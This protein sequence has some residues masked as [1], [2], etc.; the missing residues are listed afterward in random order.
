MNE[1]DYYF[2]VRSVYVVPGYDG[3]MAER[4]LHTMEGPAIEEEGHIYI[5]AKDF[6]KVYAHI[7]HVR[8]EQDQVVVSGGLKV[9]KTRKLSPTGY[10]M[11]DIRVPRGDVRRS[12]VP[13]KV[14]NSICYLPMDLVLVDGFD[15]RRYER[16][17][18]E[19]NHVCLFTDD[20]EVNG[21]PNF[22]LKLMDT[23]LRGKREG[24]Q[25]GTFWYEK[26]QKL[27][28][29]CAYLPTG[30]DGVQKLP[31]IFVLHGGNGSPVS[32]MERSSNLLQYHAEKHNMIV[33]GVDGYIRN[34]AYGYCLP[35]NPGDPRVDKS[36][37][38]NPLH[39]DDAKL[40]EYTLA[41]DALVETIGTICER[42]AADRENLFLMGNSM[43]GIGT[44]YFASAHPGMFRAISPQGGMINT[45]LAD[46]SGLA[47]LPIL[48]VGGTEDIHGFDYLRNGVEAIEEMGHN[49]R[50]T[51]VGGGEHSTAWVTALPEIFDFFEEHKKLN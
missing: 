6:A 17:T 42:Y 24:N 8:N 28:P 1:Y 46:L 18:V 45:E 40:Y 10:V 21:I 30:Y 4:Y 41:E 50:H 11:A 5:P 7:L 39:Y 25:Y 23:I 19:D 26:G 33:A 3:I 37:P 47:G 35:P 16:T 36:C 20:A 29:Y 15:Y 51:Y 32:A 9:E 43:G 34:T 13:A 22:N 49:I 48:F 27:V 2:N 44:F 31:V 12:Y 38:E 14:V